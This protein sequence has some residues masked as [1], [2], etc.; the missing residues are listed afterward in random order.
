MEGD[1]FGIAEKSARVDFFGWTRDHDR[2]RHHHDQL[3]YRGGVGPLDAHEPASERV[4]RQV[5]IE[6]TNS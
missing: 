1:A 3:R 6:A 2:H 5:R 4:T